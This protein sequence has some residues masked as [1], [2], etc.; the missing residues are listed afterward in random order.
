MRA[1]RGT[2]Y[3]PLKEHE[4]FKGEECGRYEVVNS[5]LTEAG[6]LSYEYGYSMESP[7][8]LN[9]WEAQ[10]GDFAFVAQVAID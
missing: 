5:N 7:R 3:F 4:E 8:N 9:I 2:K 6:S 1:E 10:F